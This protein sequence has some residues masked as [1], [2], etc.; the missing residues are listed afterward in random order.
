MPRIDETAYRQLKAMPTDREL[1]ELYTP[2]LDERLL[3][4][5]HTAGKSA[6]AT[7]LVLLKTFQHLGYAVAL[8]SVPM[9][10][11]SHIANQTE[12][13][14]TGQ[15]LIHYD[16]SGT[17][18]RHL[19][20]IRTHLQIVADGVAAREAMEQAMCEACESKD[21]LIDLINIA[22]EQLIRQRF[23]LPAFS[24][25]E[26]T[27][28]RIRAETTSAL[29]TVIAAALTLEEQ[30]AI[31]RLFVVD[32]ATEESTWKALKA[33]PQNPSLSHFEELME[34]ATWLMA[35]PISTDTLE[36]LP[37]VKI[38]R[39]ATE[40]LAPDANRMKEIQA[41]KRYT[42]A[43]SVLRV[44]RA[45]VLDDVAEMFCKRLLKIQHLGRETFEAAQ[46]AAQERLT[47]LIE[48]L[49][50]VTHA[51]EGEGTITERMGAIDAVYGG[52]SAQIL[53]DCEAQL[54]LMTS[55]YFPFLRTFVSRHRA[56][57][58]RFLSTVTLRSPHQ[59]KALEETIQ[60]LQASVHRSGKYLRTA[61][62]EHPH[63]QPRQ[64]IPLVDL[65]WMSDTWRRIVTGQS[66]RQ[67]S[68]ERV[69]RQHFEACVFTQILWDLKTGDLYVEGSD[70]YAN[71]WA[72]GIS[73]EEYTSSVGDYGQMLGFPVDGPGFVAHLKTWLS[74]IA[75]QV[76]QAFP[77]SRVTIERGEPVIHKA[78][79][80]KPPAGLKQ[81]EKLLALKIKDSHLLDLMVDV[82]H[83]LNWCGSFGPL[84]GFET[85]LEDAILRQMLT[86]F[87]YGTQMGP[88]QMARSFTELNS[89]HLSWIH[90]EHMSEEKLDAAITRVINGYA[91]FDL[92]RRWGSGKRAS[93]DG[94][95]WEVYTHNLLA[96]YHIRYGGYGGIGYYH[97]SDTYIAL[98]SRFIPC[99]VH[100]AIYILDGLLKN[101]SEIKPEEV[102][103]DTQAQNAVVFGLAHLLGIRLMPRIR[104]WKDLTLY[105]PTPKT[106]YEHIDALF[107]DDIDWDLIER[108]VPDLLRIVLSIK[109][110]TIT[111]STILGKLN[112]YSHKNK[113]YQA[114]RE[115]GRVIRTGFLLQ[116]LGD[117]ELRAII[118]RETNKSESFNGFAKWLAFGN[119]GVIPTNN[120]REMRKYLKYN[121][122][123]ANI[124]I[125]ANVALL[126][127]TL[128][129]LV[130]EGHRIDPEAVAALSP[131]MTQHLVR[132]GL[133]QMDRMRPPKPLIYQVSSFDPE[134]A[135]EE[136]KEAITVE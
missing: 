36:R 64:I 125:F 135:E 28:K 30:E 47:R 102:T 4:Q 27:A 77:D 6:L 63:G 126:T 38:Q 92:P 67:P 117:P 115:L 113:L 76:D 60:F 43:L 49:R 42:L 22:I 44:Q 12:C 62:S 11:V 70:R 48:V 97:V 15:D 111:A 107:S 93:A 99:G 131:Y 91:R 74:A 25:F 134:E 87:A 10:I 32:P 118:Q 100:E 83:W 75:Q 20:V 19:Q 79:R 94:T 121:H 53:T 68:P 1:R 33:D 96:E 21:D 57:L 136:A 120:R 5:R 9:P 86:V 89:R 18:R 66:R 73:W 54:A 78:P 123:L 8:S 128:N 98:F 17:R 82:Q 71:T 16:L 61:R 56:S 40:A 132:F 51:Y 81:L 41:R 108:H 7:F 122:L 88:A 110:G 50:D 69:D 85:K 114:F 31:D 129:E 2:T 106:C 80:R 124:V 84:S 104:N 37:D 39:F 95:K 59:N 26:R 58:F 23:E 52:K 105:R 127:Q 55:T 90:H 116:Y 45:Q 14:I 109:T 24:T 112:T 29:H 46:K 72:Q 13:S 35:L 3:A 119:A 133:Y 65:S 101:E 103:G 130:S 34:R